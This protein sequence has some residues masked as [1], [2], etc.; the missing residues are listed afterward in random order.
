M[1]ISEWEIGDSDMENIGYVL[2]A[3][4]AVAW[5]AAIIAES[6]AAFP[7]GIVG[8]AAIL[9]F[10]FLLAKVC[11]DRLSSTEDDHYSSTVKK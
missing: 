1:L 2:L 9:G 6:I 11:K 5:I 7:V 8:L 10:G 3:I 4:A